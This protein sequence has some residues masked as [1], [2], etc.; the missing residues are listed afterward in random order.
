MADEKQKV[1]P[2]PAGLAE[3]KNERL[4]VRQ[5]GSDDDPL[6]QDG[7]VGTDPIYQNH[8]SVQNQPFEGGEESED[9]KGD[10]EPKQAAK[11]QPAKAK[12]GDDEGDKPKS[13]KS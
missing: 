6:N 9:D 7:Y 12:A 1:E 4:E 3:V 5:P 10:D 2:V 11:S 8:A 13:A